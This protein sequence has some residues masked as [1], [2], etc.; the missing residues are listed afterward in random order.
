MSPRY[1]FALNRLVAGRFNGEWR[2]PVYLGLGLEVA[3]LCRHVEVDREFIGEG[4][5]EEIIITKVADLVGVVTLSNKL[6]PT[7]REPRQ[8]WALESRE[9]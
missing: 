7:T 5:G 1:C 6:E 9:S 3:I 2:T 8:A 4:V